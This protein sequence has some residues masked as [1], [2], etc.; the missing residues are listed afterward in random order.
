MS[1]CAKFLRNL[2]DFTHLVTG[3]IFIEECELLK[4][5]YQPESI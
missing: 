1:S 3:R 4:G 2:A 5:F